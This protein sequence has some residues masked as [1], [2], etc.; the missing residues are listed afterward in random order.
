MTKQWSTQRRRSTRQ[1]RSD[2]DAR[3]G[4]KAAVVAAAPAGAGK[5]Y[6][7]AETVGLLRA[8][9]KS[10]GVA[11]P[12]NEQSY[13]LIAALRQQE[14]GLDVR[15]VPA[16]NKRLS[17]AQCSSH[18]DNLEAK[19]I[20]PRAHGVVVATLNKLADALSRYPIPKYDVLIIDEAYQADATRYYGAADIA[21]TH[22][23]VGDSGQLD[24]FTTLDDASWWKGG[25][26]DP[27]QTAV[28]AL[29]RNHPTT[30]VHPLPITRRLDPRAVPVAQAFYPGHPFSAAM[31]PGVR[32]LTLRAAPGGEKKYAVVDGSL[33][34]A[35][36]SGW[37]Y[38]RLPA[39]TT[40]PPDPLVASMIV[41]HVRRLLERGAR[42]RCERD[43]TPRSIGDKD[44]AVGVTHNLQKDRVRAEL[45]AAG[46]NKI[47]VET[48]NRLQ[49]LQY[50]VVVA[51]HP[52][53]GQPAPDAFHL[54]RGRLCVLLTRHRHA[55]IVVG[56]A[57]DRQ[58][59]D[60]I[61]PATPGFLGVTDDPVL[62]GWDAHQQV[63]EI[64][65]RHV[66]EP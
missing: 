57:S 15:F 1:S 36:R 53:A 7:V 17:P 34:E 39:A 27:L 29:T 63:F 66:V 37:S 46:L 18:I 44:I 42:V 41:D 64:L 50:E 6:F 61:P 60:G 20:D 54:D 14:P 19:D 13:S 56:R 48:A 65:E 2:L 30:P 8:A 26:E 33:D 52:L 49:G 25:V 51:W 32:T 23:L 9:G 10:V 12:T 21:A 38:V 62:D 22:L 40:M 59:L 47:V 16:S 55:C 3:V 58:L 24:P 5:S 43:E 28:G 31:L 11:T 45:D 4:T 35:A